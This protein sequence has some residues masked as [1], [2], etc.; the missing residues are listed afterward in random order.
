MGLDL[1]RGTQWPGGVLGAIGALILVGVVFQEETRDHLTSTE[2]VAA[3]VV[4]A[5]LA[6]TGPLVIAYT[7]VAARRAAVDL[8]KA[9]KGSYVGGRDGL[10]RS[11]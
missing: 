8:D 6:L 4:G 11:G 3:L 2:F 9:A 5:L 10:D 7:A 1:A